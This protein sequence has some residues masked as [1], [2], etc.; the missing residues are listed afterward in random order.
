[1]G[2]TMNMKVV[3]R[4]HRHVEKPSVGKQA[5]D[6]VIR[7]DAVESHVVLVPR[8]PVRWRLLQRI[9]NADLPYGKWGRE[10]PF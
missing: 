5:W 10:V 3:K 8:R 6:S 2:L 4:V 9:W 1:M 7:S